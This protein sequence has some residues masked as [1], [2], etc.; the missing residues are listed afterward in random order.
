MKSRIT[1]SI[2]RSIL[3]TI[4]MATIIIYGNCAK[5]SSGITT[6]MIDSVCNKYGYAVGKYWTYK[7]EANKHKYTASTT[8]A[9][10]NGY[11]GYTFGGGSQC[12]AFSRFLMS[13]VAGKEVGKDPSWKKISA[14]K[15]TSL[16]VGDVVC[17]GD[18]VHT[19]V[20]YKDLGGGKFQFIEIWTLPKYGHVIKKGGYNGTNNNTLAAI[21]KM[22]LVYVYRYEGTPATAVIT[23]AKATNITSDGA[24]I[25][26]DVNPAKTL[27]T[28]QVT[29][30]SSVLGIDKHKWITKASSI[31]GK[32]YVFDMKV[33]SFN[34]QRGLYKS[35]IHVFYTDGTKDMIA[36]PIQFTI[37]E[38]THVHNYQF[39]R[40]GKESTCIEKG[41][42]IYRCSCGAEKTEYLNFGSHKEIIDKA[43]S[44]SCTSD[45]LTEG[46]HC[47]VCGKV[48]EEQQRIPAV[49]H[50][51]DEGVITKN[52]TTDS[53]GV[54]TYTC[55]R[56]SETRFESIP[57]IINMES[58]EGEDERGD[59]EDTSVDKEVFADEETYE[60]LD[61]A[62]YTTENLDS[63]HLKSNMNVIDNKSEA[64]YRVTKL[65]RK[66]GKVIG[67]TVT[68]IAPCDKNCKSVNIP[69]AIN[70]SGIKFKVTILGK[71]ALKNCKKLTRVTIGVNVTKIGKN[72]FKGCSKL[73]AVI[74]KTE[75]IKTIGKNAFVG[76]NSKAK[77]KFPKRCSKRYAIMI[78][79][80][81]IPK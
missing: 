61:E 9:G 46:R 13:E 23:N 74:F 55:T 3:T 4:M 64:Q 43:V 68:Y 66:K 63:E 33:A 69:A 35:N 48:T 27:K 39:N 72:A 45:G 11:K 81:K 71:D 76:I 12:W 8:K 22:G 50:D 31:N 58:T 19:A 56:C 75:K 38:P 52:A 54:R 34:N 29:V 77:I 37:P 5:A 59:D 47:S 53:E 20:V 32:H 80:A 41:Y 42:N 16:K 62:D 1:K 6:S 28:V 36:S 15:V 10:V 78:K 30:W 49:G 14:A 26:C 24:K 67:G 21:K 2:I 44:A 79:K 7:G 40:V 60:D 65:S 17:I 73:K 25:E 18:T 70:I 57:K 51:W